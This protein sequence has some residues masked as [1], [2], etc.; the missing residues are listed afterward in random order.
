MH[1]IVRDVESLREF[2][3]DG[4]WQDIKIGPQTVGCYYRVPQSELK[5]NWQAPCALSHPELNALVLKFL[6]PKFPCV[7]LGSL[8]TGLG[9]DIAQVKKAYDKSEKATTHRLVWG[10][11]G[12]MSQIDLDPRHVGYGRPKSGNATKLMKKH[13]A[14]LLIAERP[15]LSTESL[16]AMCSPE[17]LLTTAFW[18]TR[19]K[20]SPPVLEVL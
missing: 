20:V 6:G 3:T 7:P 5:R 2:V 19:P 9:T 14:R 17:P 16:L 12:V 13:S 11:P 8:V 4:V 10:H 18:E 1:Q 15:H